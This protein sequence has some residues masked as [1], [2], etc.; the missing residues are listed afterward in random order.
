PRVQRGEFRPPRAIDPAIDRA[1]E[2]V[3]LQAMALRPEDRYGSARALAEEIERWMADEPVGAWHEP[4]ARRA[5]RGARRNRTAVTGAEAAVLAGLI[6]L[7]AVA[8]IQSRSN[9]ELTAANEK[10]S[11]ALQ[12]ETRAKHDAT[13]ALGQSEAARQRAEAVLGFLKNDV[14]ASAR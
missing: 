10:T 8:L 2:A 1:L 6:G 4:V 14:L 5:R 9:R 3:C 13:E 7:A 11:R 12:A